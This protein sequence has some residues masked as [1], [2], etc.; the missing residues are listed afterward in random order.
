MAVKYLL[1]VLIS[2]WPP[3]GGASTSPPHTL[4]I[5]DIQNKERCEAAA[6]AIAERWTNR[7]RS[8]DTLCIPA[9]NP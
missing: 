4:A 7:H 6:K 3:N 1:V 8:V 9:V 2:Y 5:V